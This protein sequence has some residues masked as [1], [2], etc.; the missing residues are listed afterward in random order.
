M[1]HLFQLP[2]PLNSFL[3]LFY[4]ALYFWHIKYMSGRGPWLPMSLCSSKCFLCLDNHL[5]LRTWVI[6]YCD[7]AEQTLFSFCFCLSCLADLRVLPFGLLS[8]SRDL[9]CGDGA[10]L[11]FPCMFKCSISSASSALTLILCLVK[12]LADDSIW[13]LYLTNWIFNSISVW[14][15]T[16]QIPC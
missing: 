8:V 5:L 2:L 9:G 4:F 3:M 12:S 10:L 6:F 11:A 16:S 7:S 1:S 13:F 15:F 14:F